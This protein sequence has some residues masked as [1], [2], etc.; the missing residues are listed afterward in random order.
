MATQR[1]CD[2]SSVFS[3]AVPSPP[4][5][6]NRRQFFGLTLLGITRKSGREIGGGFV[7]E[8]IAIGHRLRDGAR[9]AM[10]QRERKVPI[11]I[12]GGGIAG[13]SAAWRLHKRNADF[14]VLE[15]EETAG[16]NAR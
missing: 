11:V 8:S 9:F 13:L 1:L 4:L 6:L 12:V 7:H 2:R 3:V 16:G 14:V 5:R 10:P 15:M